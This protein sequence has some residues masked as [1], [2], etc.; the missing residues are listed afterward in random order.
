MAA[1]A[2][3]TAMPLPW[4]LGA[5]YFMFFVYGGAY[6][7]YFPLYLANR[8][9]SAVEIAWVLALPP[10]ARTF[11]PAAWGW[12]ADRTGAHRA[13][14]AFSCAVTAASFALMPFVDDIALLVALMSVLSA[15]ALPL[16]ESITLG[17]L[18]DQPGRYGPIRLWGSVGFIAAVLAGGAWLDFQPVATL[19][20]ALVAFMLATLLVTLWLPGTGP[21]AAA[22]AVWPRFT[23]EIR[24]LLAAGFCMAVAH[25]ALYAFF[26]L[27]LEQHGY[28]GTMIGML[29]T[30]GVLAEILVFL[31]LPQLFRRYTLSSI[32]LASFVC[33]VLRF[34]AIGWGA[35]ELWVV[36]L[37]QL[38]HAATF[39]SF[40]AA[41]VAAV[42]RVF[43][44]TAQATGQTLFSSVSYGAGA[45]AGTLLAG[46][47]WEAGGGQLAFSVAAGAALAGAFF[48]GQ[49]KRAG[50]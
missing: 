19:P 30:L 50:L 4:R 16:V 3:L 5:F 42:H 13:I 34:V 2:N 22:E 48:A 29:W 41:S 7:A 27:Y 39:G 45:A 40:H 10:L 18:A 11:A 14:V 12:L 20:V 44:P 36:L 32:L 8:G 49:L 15:G 33:A 38:L 35:A 43:P 47:N 37:A 31:Y 46:W 28:S 23:L 1:D 21:R 17:S 25:G 9:L 6:V 24:S 26:T